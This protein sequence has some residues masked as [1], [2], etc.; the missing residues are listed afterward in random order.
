MR[1]AVALVASLPFALLAALAAAGEDEAA[2][3]AK[4]VE[5]RFTDPKV[6]PASPAPFAVTLSIRMPS[7]GWKLAVDEVAE[8][9][10]AGRIVAKATATR[11][12]GMGAQ[13]I[14]PMTLSVPVG[15]PSP[16]DYLLEVHLREG[17]GD[18][19]RAAA[20]LLEA[21]K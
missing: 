4:V 12:V 2:G 16:G 5:P 10:A 21:V 13:V 17:D 1:P 8:P 15:S 9:D 7:A 6:E 18:Y 20:V 19:R 14:T 3:S 11:P